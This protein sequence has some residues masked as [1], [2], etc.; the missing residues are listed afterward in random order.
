MS[1]R[2]KIKQLIGQCYEH[3]QSWTGVGQQI[4]NKEEF[5]ELIIAECIEALRLVPYNSDREF[6]DEVV[7]QQAIKQHFS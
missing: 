4:F 5:A 2:S 6:G 7:Y 1:N 3:D